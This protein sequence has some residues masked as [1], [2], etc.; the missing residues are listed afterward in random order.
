M[1]EER[2]ELGALAITC[3]RGGTTFPEES[4]RRPSAAAAAAVVAL[5]DADSRP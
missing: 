2:S 1:A 3:D 5:G 4:K